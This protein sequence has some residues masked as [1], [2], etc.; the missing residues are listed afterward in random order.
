MGSNLQQ[1]EEERKKGEHAVRKVANTVLALFCHTIAAS[2]L[3][4]RHYLL[5]MWSEGALCCASDKVRD[6][7]RNGGWS[8]LKLYHV[9][10]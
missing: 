2:C 6:R 7:E 5:E 10:E 8:K 4:Q 9:V 3:S 1:K